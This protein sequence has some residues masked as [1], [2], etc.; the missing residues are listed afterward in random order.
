MLYYDPLIFSTLVMAI[1]YRLV[2]YDIELCNSLLF[3]HTDSISYEIYCTY[4][5]CCSDIPSQK[6]LFST[7]KWQLHWRPNL[8]AQSHYGFCSH[9]LERSENPFKRKPN[10][11]LI[12]IW[13]G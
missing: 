8:Q 3:S 13:V 7:M 11:G 9:A 2:S 4:K 10:H 12:I 6:I 1:Y 5:D